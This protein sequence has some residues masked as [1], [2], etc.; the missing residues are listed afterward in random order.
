V[1]ILLAIWAFLIEANLLIVHQ[2]TI[3][4]TNWP[5]GLDELKV[6]AISDIHAGSPFIDADKLRLLVDKTNDTNPDVIVLLGDFVVPDTFPMIS[7]AVQLTLA[8]HTHG[9][10]VNLPILGR[11]IV[12]SKLW[13]TL[14]GRS[15]SGRTETSV[16]YNGCR[17]KRVSR[18]IS[19][20]AR[21]CCSYCEISSLRLAV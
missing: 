20:V 10:Q 12:P 6:A 7:P 3:T 1:A 8:G 18:S 19:R 21:D 9:G 4:L 17:D 5:S 15:H 14:R 2:E 13:A 11:P 16:C